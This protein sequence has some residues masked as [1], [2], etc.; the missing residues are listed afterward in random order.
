MDD[1]HDMDPESMDP[2]YDCEDPAEEPDDADNLRIIEELLLEDEDDTTSSDS[3]DSDSDADE[4]VV[5]R[6]GR[7]SGWG[8]AAADS[9]SRALLGAIQ[10]AGSN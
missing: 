3:D 4:E 5:R 10:Q 6:G 9:V 2:M 1:E 8:R 7:G